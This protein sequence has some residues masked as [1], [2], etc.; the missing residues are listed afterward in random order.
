LGDVTITASAG[1]T[2]NNATPGLGDVTAPSIFGSINVTKA[3]IY[4][5]IQTTSGDIGQAIVGTGGQI[6]GVTTIVSHTAMTGK[7]ISRGNLVS[8]ITVG[9]A[10]TGVIAAQGDIGAIQRDSSGNAVLT[11]NALTRF[12]GIT[13]SG[14]DSGQIIAL[15]N[16]FGSMTISGTMT[17]RIAVKGQAV[18]GLAASRVGI[19]G[20]VNISSFAAGSA[21]ISGGRVGDVTGNTTAHFGN[22][23]GF[24]AAEGSVNLS[25]T[26]IG[27]NN[28]LQNVTS[29]LNFTVI[30]AIF[31]D[32]SLSLLFD[33][34]GSL[35]GLGLIE[36]D[37]TNIQDNSGS[38]SGT[39]S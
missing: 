9:G 4:G 18:A 37:L 7:I 35:N 17:G 33:T 27:S 26:T 11:A 2:V 39:I 23:L 1:S 31:T 32:S 30:N 24:I 14:A 25:S 19:L 13:I 21:V 29:G 12:G 10:F 16:I 15:G 8:S 5:T 3:G 6:T 22:A 20:N 38:L 34:G 36:T 28:L